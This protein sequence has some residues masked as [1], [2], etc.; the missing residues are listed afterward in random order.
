MSE[1]RASPLSPLLPWA[2]VGL[3]AA[4]VMAMEPPS[5]AFVQFDATPTNLLD[6]DEV[7]AKLRTTHA[8]ALLMGDSRIRSAFQATALPE[9]FAACGLEARQP[10][11]V[12]A[13]SY[14]FSRVG[15]M[16]PRLRALGARLVVLQLDL[17][18]VDPAVLARDGRVR[19]NRGESALVLGRE[20]VNQLRTTGATVVVVDLPRSEVEAAR[21]GP[22]FA[23]RWEEGVRQ[24]EAL[25]VAMVRSEILWEDALYK[26][27]V[28][29]NAA[30]AA[31]VRRW[32]CA[33]LPEALSGHAPAHR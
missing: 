12:F 27:H 20:L 5:L 8:D 21:R 17:F 3:V 22:E 4:G 23:Q 24:V 14:D 33:A 26:D 6:Q 15:P 31:R 13:P 7:F 30:G 10:V 2:L 32:L 18:I 16:V 9:W 29:Y 28:H 25:D 1:T 19:A 11:A